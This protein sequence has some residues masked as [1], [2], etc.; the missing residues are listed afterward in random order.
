MAHLGRTDG[1]RVQSAADQHD[2]LGGAGHQ[3]V[4]GAEGAQRQQFAVHHRGRHQGRGRAARDDQPG[5]AFEP[6]GHLVGAGERRLDQR[7]LDGFTCQSRATDGVIR[8][9][10][11]R[12]HQVQPRQHPQR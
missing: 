2:A 10:P 3:A 7:F 8:C 9:G 6:S 4:V 12:R 11:A 5:E 1:L